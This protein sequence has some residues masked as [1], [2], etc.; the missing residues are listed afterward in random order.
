M[1]KGLTIM[2][3]CSCCGFKEELDQEI[4]A[5]TQTDSCQLCP[6]CGLDEME[7]E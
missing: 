5:A 2:L 1:R 3:F 4:S 6:C 7:Y